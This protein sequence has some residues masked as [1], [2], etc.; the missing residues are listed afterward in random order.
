[1]NMKTILIFTSVFFSTFTGVY[2]Q[3]LFNNGGFE[4]W[5]NALGYNEPEHW[6]SLNSLSTITGAGYKESTVSTF[7]AY[8]G[9]QAALLTSQQ[10]NFQ[11]IPGV[12][13]SGSLFDEQGEPDLS[14]LG[15]PFANRPTSFEFYYKYLPAIGDSAVGYV[16]LSKWNTATQKRDTIGLGEFSVGDSIKSYVKRVVNIVYSSATQPDS[17]VVFFST[18]YDGFNPMVGSQLFIDE[19]RLNFPVGLND[20]LTDNH[21]FRMY[22][23]PS[24]GYVTIVLN[25]PKAEVAV[26]NVNGKKIFA[27]TSQ[28]ATFGISTDGWKAGVYIVEV[29]QEGK[30]VH[31]KLI[32]Q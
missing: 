13:S 28:Q 4:M 31:N 3:T 17:I 11:D 1:M 14:N 8:A 26:Y 21:L 5:T 24:N 32:I 7:E 2:A 9:T 23:N 6:Y 16:M 30:M 15:T 19:F 10:N 18:S 25:E 22:P 12:L 29:I 27:E 20:A